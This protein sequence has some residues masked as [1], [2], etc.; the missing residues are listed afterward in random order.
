MKTHLTALS[1]TL[2]LAVTA[3]EARW[4]KPYTPSG[5]PEVSI[6][7]TDKAKIAN[8]VTNGL[9]DSG[10]ML[11]QQQ[12][13]S[14]TYECSKE[15]MGYR[16]RIMVVITDVYGGSRVLMR[17]FIFAPNANHKGTLQY[18]L[19]LKPV[20]EMTHKQKY[21]EPD[22]QFL[23]RLKT[24]LESPEAQANIPIKAYRV[25]AQL[26]PLNPEIIQNQKLKITSGL[27]VSFLNPGFPADKAGLK[28]GDVIETVD[29]QAISTTE[30]FMALT[31]AAGN[32]KPMNCKV[33]RRGETLEVSIIPQYVE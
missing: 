7:S 23:E 27:F 8:A 31:Q 16:E 30:Q 24:F 17:S 5:F 1:I 6:A 11:T 14:L 22:M 32:S 13:Y 25:G 19:G 20:Q 21:Y 9:A 4:V 29:G 3:A 28:L 12:D 15:S 18:E 2:L 26:V 10:C 33:H